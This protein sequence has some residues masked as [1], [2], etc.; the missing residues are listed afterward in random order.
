MAD[1]E[2]NRIENAEE[3]AVESSKKDASAKDKS[4][5]ANKKPGIFK[6]IAKYFKECKSEMKKIVWSSGKQTFNNTVVVI[7][8]MIV[9]GAVVVGLD[10]LFRWIIQGLIS[11]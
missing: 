2:M 6:R 11:L 8:A 10:Y 9:I 7:I 1:T 3:E 4:K 5:K